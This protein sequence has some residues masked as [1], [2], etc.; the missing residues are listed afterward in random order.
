MTALIL[1]ILIFLFW[2]FFVFLNFERY[3]V[4]QATLSCFLDRSF[5]EAAAMMVTHTDSSIMQAFHLKQIRTVIKRSLGFLIEYSISIYFMAHIVVIQQGTFSTELFNLG[6]TSATI[7]MRQA[8]NSTTFSVR[9][10]GKRKQE[11]SGIDFQWNMVL[12]FYSCTAFCL[13]EQD[14]RSKRSPE[15][16]PGF[17]CWTA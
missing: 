17:K 11:K 10:H 7:A 15:D 1:S 12:R 6:K 5:I 16:L 2:C 8:T 4:D 14:P 13:F 9:N 3:G